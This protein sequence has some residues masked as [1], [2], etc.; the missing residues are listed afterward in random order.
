MAVGPL[1]RSETNGD[2]AHVS[3]C[4]SVRS[5]SKQAPPMSICLFSMKRHGY[6]SRWRNVNFYV[7]KVNIIAIKVCITWTRVFST[8]FGIISWSFTSFSREACSFTGRI[9][10]STA[11]GCTRWPLWPLTPKTFS[12]IGEKIS[13]TQI[14]SQSRQ[15]CLFLQVIPVYAINKGWF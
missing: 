4:T 7:Q 5:L 2:F 11:R 10:F 3:Y 12:N 13:E 9:T 1:Y 8:L 14:T 15:V 6:L